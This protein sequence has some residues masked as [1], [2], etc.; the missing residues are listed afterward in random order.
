MFQKNN[1]FN[2]LSIYRNKIALISED[3]KKISY[4]ELLKKANLI[5]SKIQK[6]KSLIFLIGQNNFET[7]IGYVSFIKNGHTVVFLDYKIN[8]IFLKKLI[9]KYKPNYIFCEKHKKIISYKKIINFES[10]VL[11]EK[12]KKS[13]LKIYENLMLLMPTSGTTGSVKFVRQSYENLQSNTQNII[14]FLKIKKNHVTITSL[15]ISY[16]YGLSI[17]NTHLKSGSAIVLTNKSMV[18][19]FFWQLMDKYKVTSFGGVPFQ[20]AI[21]EKFFKKRVPR[22]LKYTTQAGGKM[23]PVLIRN[24]IKIYKKNKIKL[25]QM[26]GA[27]EATSRMSYLKW[28]DSSKKIGSIGKSIPGGKLYLNNASGKLIT[29]N[30][31]QGEL[32]YQGKNVCLGYA[33]N[34]NDLALENKKNKILNTGDIAYKDR[35][36]F[37]YIVGRK[38]RYTK[39]YGSRV[40]LFELENILIKKGIDVIMK[41]EKDDQILCYFKRAGDI[42]N[43]IRYLSKLTLINMKVFVGKLISKKNLTNNLKF[44]V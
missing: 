34:L 44:K 14:K 22:S 19:N 31:I 29:K 18:E 13:N 27:A 24:L 9:F 23:N 26:Y 25:I 39:I 8:K 12:I 10:Y 20:Y 7:V 4:S 42:N 3:N 2:N 17:I 15:P 35:E 32:I 33:E 28:Q 36:N 43:G 21:V 37:F 6:T 40:N 11:L 30:G 1:F 41:S 38:N 16:V 5:S